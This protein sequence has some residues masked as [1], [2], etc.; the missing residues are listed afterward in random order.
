MD[1]SFKKLI[2]QDQ[3]TRQNVLIVFLIVL[4]LVGFVYIYNALFSKPVEPVVSGESA[5]SVSGKSITSSEASEIVINKIR[6]DIK[7]T[8]NELQDS[9]YAKLRE[10]NPSGTGYSDPG[11]NNPFKP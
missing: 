9:F 4:F 6:K 7:N 1:F 2:P 11:R 5:V 3:K 10:F 8:K